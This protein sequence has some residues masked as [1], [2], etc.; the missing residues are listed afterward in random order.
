VPIGTLADVVGETQGVFAKTF[1]G[2]Q[3]EIMKRR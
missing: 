2:F 3:D 1:R